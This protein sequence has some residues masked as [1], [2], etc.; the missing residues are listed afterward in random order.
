MQIS[1]RVMVMMEGTTYE[2]PQSSLGLRDGRVKGLWV[3]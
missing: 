2:V 3:A 1:V